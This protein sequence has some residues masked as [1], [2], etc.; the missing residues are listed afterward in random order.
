VRLTFDFL[1]RR[2]KDATLDENAFHIEDRGDEK[3][4]RYGS[5]TYSKV[6]SRGIYTGQYWDYFIPAAYAFPNPRILIIG[7]GGGT[8]AFQLST[9]LRENAVIDAIDMS[10]RAVE[11]SK[12]MIPRSSAN[13]MIGDGAEHVRN[14][15]GRYDLAILDAY[16]SSHI[17]RQF[18][19]SEFVDDAH[20]ALSQDGIMVINYAVSF[21]GIAEFW[22]YVKMLKRRFRV[23]RVDASPSEDNAILI[24]SKSLEKEE[25]L[26]GINQRLVENE[27]TSAL[28]RNYRRMKLL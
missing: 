26:K 6:K 1:R 20:R 16:V 28:L 24:C 23:Y 7:F 21:M 2:R 3:V 17:P 9:L 22:N 5:I 10:S 11:L 19:R 14:S 15:N 18:L 4:L 8:T 13:I 12:N 27:D 25:I